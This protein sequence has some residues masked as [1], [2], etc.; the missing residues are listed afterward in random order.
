MLNPKQTR[1]K[2]SRK[3]G[4]VFGGRRY[5]KIADKVF[6]RAHS[7]NKPHFTDI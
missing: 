2:K 6:N 1:W 4:D 5:P 7:L 3:F